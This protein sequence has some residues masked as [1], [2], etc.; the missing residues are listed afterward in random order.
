[1]NRNYCDRGISQTHIFNFTTRTIDPVTAA[2]HPMV[3]KPVH[4]PFT[5]KFTIC[6]FVHP[7]PLLSVVLINED[8]KRQD[9]RLYG[10]IR[11]Q[12][13]DGVLSLANSSQTF[14]ILD[15]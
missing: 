6:H 5:E 12:Y 8:V 1:M 3:V 7:L 11:A 10:R 2:L 13:D 9:I 15:I 14:A 4:T